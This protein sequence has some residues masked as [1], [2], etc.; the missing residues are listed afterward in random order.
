MRNSGKKPRRAGA[1]V[2]ELVLLRRFGPG[3]YRG[4][5]RGQGPQAGRAG[6]PKSEIRKKLEK[7]TKSRKRN[8]RAACEQFGLLQCSVPELVQLPLATEA[9]RPGRERL[10][11]NVIKRRSA[12]PSGGCP[13]RFRDRA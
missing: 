11:P 3:A 5:A 4:P 10:L 13:P 9:P 2:C 6:N 1:R 7:D 8:F 12:R